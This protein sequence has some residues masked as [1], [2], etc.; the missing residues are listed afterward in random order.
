MKNLKIK[1]DV[2]IVGSG[3]VGCVLAERLSNDLNLKCL[4]V[5]KRDHVAGNCFDLKNNKGLLYHK[6]GPH[7]L[8]FKN[9]KTFNYLSKFTKW[10]KG[11]YIVKSY[12]DKK[13]YNF[14][15]NINTL[16]KLFNL[17]FKTIEE[18]KKFLDKKKIK[19]KSPKNSE[20]FILS[21]VGKEIYEKF[22]KNYSKKQ[23]GIHPRLLNKSVLGRVPIRLNRDNFYVNEKLKFMPK[24]GYTAMFKNMISNKNISIKLNTDFKK[25]KKNIEYKILI[26]TGPVDEYFDYKFGKLEWRSLKFKFESFKKK[27]LQE[28]VQYNFPNDFKFTRKVEIKHVTKQKSNYTIISKEYPTKHGDPFY[29]INTKKNSVL[30]LKYLKLVKK[31]E[32]KQIYFEGRLATY[33][34]INTDEVI[35]NALSLFEKIKKKF[36]K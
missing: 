19:I 35:E 18:A 27:Y 25:I 7:Y 13:L 8:R 26:Y 14:P 10:I 2:L 28:C 36:R 1:T 33:R 6:Y 12:V 31:L 4:I 5:E 21:Q 32:K 24:D 11:D 3:P 20:E 22:Y 16:E 9:K 30:Y 15:I 17:K 29:P 34:Y 23:W